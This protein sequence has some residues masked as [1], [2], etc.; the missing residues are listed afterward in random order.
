MD[1]CSSK[2]V[3]VLISKA[4]VFAAAIAACAGLLWLVGVLLLTRQTFL[5]LIL[6]LAIGFVAGGM[7]FLAWKRGR[8]VLS[9]LAMAVFVLAAAL[10][11]MALVVVLEP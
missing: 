11:G 1:P 5:L 4:A 3:A 8:R 10:G 9:A 7:A 2:K 6:M